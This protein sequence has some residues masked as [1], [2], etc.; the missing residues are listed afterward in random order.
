MRP[1]E[2]FDTLSAIDHGQAQ[3]AH[4]PHAN[5]DA[6]SVVNSAVTFIQGAGTDGY[7]HGYGEPTRGSIAANLLAVLAPAAGTAAW[8]ARYL[9]DLK[10]ALRSVPRFDIA[11]L[12]VDGPAAA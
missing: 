8:L 11:S 10:H 2:Q 4:G 7:D 6:A 3:D 12:A 5:G 9:P 1:G